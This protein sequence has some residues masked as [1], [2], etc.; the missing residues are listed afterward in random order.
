[1]VYFKI[2]VCGAKEG[3]H[4]VG[5]S[6]N[7]SKQFFGLSYV[8]NRPYNVTFFRLRGVIKLRG[9]FGVR[10]VWGRVFLFRGYLPT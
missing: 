10:N 2:L 7:F 9:I 5:N 6:Y 4:P 1:M 8:N 3:Y